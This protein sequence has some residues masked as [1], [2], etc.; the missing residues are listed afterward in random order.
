M[1]MTYHQDLQEAVMTG[2]NLVTLK[3]AYMMKSTA[4]DVYATFADQLPKVSSEA[5]ELIDKIINIQLPW[6]KE[7]LEK[8]QGKIAAR[9]L[10][11]HEDTSAETSFET[12][13]R[14]ELATYSLSLLRVYASHMAAAQITGRNLAMEVT[15][16]LIDKQMAK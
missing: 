16:K 2:E 15:E 4:P 6:Q 3:Y 8:Y 9:P 10:Y 13:L 5:R 7:V 12:Y 11:Q 1:C 14:A